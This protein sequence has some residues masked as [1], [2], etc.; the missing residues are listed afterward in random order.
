MIIL[1]A[2]KCEPLGSPQS[3]RHNIGDHRLRRKYSRIYAALWTGP[4]GT[5]FVAV[6]IRIT[7]CDILQVHTGYVHTFHLNTNSGEGRHPLMISQRAPGMGKTPVFGA[8]P[9]LHFTDQLQT[10]RL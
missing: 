9:P 2:M 6:F 8:L 10:G 4:E 3:G 7:T 5:V 1:R